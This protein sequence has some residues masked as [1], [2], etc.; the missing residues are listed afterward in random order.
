MTTHFTFFSLWMTK[1][2]CVV[3]VCLCMFR[4]SFFYASSFY[5]SSFNIYLI[6]I[7]SISFLQ[8]P[9]NKMLYP[10]F[11]LETVLIYLF[12]WIQTLFC[13]LSLSLNLSL[14]S[15]IFFHLLSICRFCQ[16][17]STISVFEPLKNGGKVLWWMWCVR[18]ALRP[19]RIF[20]WC[21]Y[22]TLSIFFGPFFCICRY[23]I[24]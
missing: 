7:L 14:F 2:M 10:F 22:F 6:H 23:A 20:G 12:I 11:T 4:L 9:P 16:F 15:L 3:C 19:F 21:N 17:I 8:P 1:W 5:E 13:S 24:H 18:R